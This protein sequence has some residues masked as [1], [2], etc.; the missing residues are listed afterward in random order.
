[1]IYRSLIDVTRGM[2]FEAYLNPSDIAAVTCVISNCKNENFQTLC[3]LE[4]CTDEDG[5][6]K[7]LYCICRKQQATFVVKLN[8]VSYAIGFSICRKQQATFLVK[9]NSV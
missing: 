5:V 2:A 8:S 7:I 6:L 9:F 1:M 4:H 3:L